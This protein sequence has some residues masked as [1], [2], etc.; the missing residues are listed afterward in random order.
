MATV[1]QSRAAE[2]KHNAASQA[3]R[4]RSS[5]GQLAGKYMR[6]SFVSLEAQSGNLNVFIFITIIVSGKKPH[7]YWPGAQA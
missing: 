4:G 2:G 7:W 3:R 5:P 6:D 1:R